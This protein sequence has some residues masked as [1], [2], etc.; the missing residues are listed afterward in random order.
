MQS[1]TTFE[2]VNIKDNIG[3]P[4]F[5]CP[6][7]QVHSFLDDLTKICRK[8]NVEE[9]YLETER[10]PSIV[11]RFTDGSVYED[12]EYARG[13]KASVWSPEANCWVGKQ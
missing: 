2:P 1:S 4:S 9:I 8:N 13:E 5:P 7:S 11:L 3:S 6:K 12:L 10:S